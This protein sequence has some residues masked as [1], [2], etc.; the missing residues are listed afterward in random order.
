MDKFISNHEYMAELFDKADLAKQAGETG[1]AILAARSLRL[2]DIAV[3][4]EGESA[5]GYKRIQRL[6]KRADP[7]LALWRLFQEEA[8]FVI[9]DPTE[10]ERPQAWKTE[11]VGKLIN[12][13]TR[14]FWALILATPYRGWA[15]PCGMLTYSSRTMAQQADSRNLNHYRAFAALKDL[16]GGRPLVLDREF[17]HLELM[18]N[19]VEEQINWDIRLNLRANPPKFHNADGKEVALMIS[20]GET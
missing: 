4:M 14:G 5:A 3:E 7:P 16:L 12:G 15:I 13:K 6:L 18:L 2:T 9:G 8:E 10:I 17:S 1:E 11:Y 20:P 19:L